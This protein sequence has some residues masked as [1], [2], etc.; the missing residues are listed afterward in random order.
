MPAAVVDQYVFL[1]RPML[2]S[3]PS[4][5]GEGGQQYHLIERIEVITEKSDSNGSDDNDSSVNMDSSVSVVVE[6]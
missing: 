5:V 6:E 4:P 1:K 3:G 2:L